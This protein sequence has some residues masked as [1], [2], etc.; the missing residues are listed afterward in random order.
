[1]VVFTTIAKTQGLVDSQD[2]F[3]WPAPWH[4]FRRRH[5]KAIFVSGAL[6]PTEHLVTTFVKRCRMIASQEFL[7]FDVVIS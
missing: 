6:V 5:F 4:Y 2:F 1:M 7:T 3:I